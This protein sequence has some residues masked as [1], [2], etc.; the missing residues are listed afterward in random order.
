MTVGLSTATA[1]KL[2]RSATVATRSQNP[3]LADVTGSATVALA[4]RVNNVAQAALRQNS[5]A[6]SFNESAGNTF[7]LDF[8]GVNQGGNLTARLAAWNRAPS[9]AP[10]DT[11]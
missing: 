2:S 4:E 11:L 10:S 7:T 3:N 9:G 6:G 1:G 8:G 5:G